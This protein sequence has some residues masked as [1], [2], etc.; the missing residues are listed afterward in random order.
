MATKKDQVYNC[1]VCTNVVKVL[2]QGVG[3][4][5]CCGKP[6]ELKGK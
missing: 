2:D 1:Q 6:M 4:L 3:I 5:V